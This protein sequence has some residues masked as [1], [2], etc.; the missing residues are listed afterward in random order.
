M[1]V[2]K[3]DILRVIKTLSNI[4]VKGEQNL[5]MLYASIMFLT[6]MISKD[7]ASSEIDK[8]E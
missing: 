1:E 3:N 7:A 4:E 5:S 8:T 6:N 2:E